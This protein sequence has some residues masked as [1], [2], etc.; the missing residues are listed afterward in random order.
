MRSAFSHCDCHSLKCP[1]F[2]I[3]FTDNIVTENT[4][5]MIFSL[6]LNKTD[7]NEFT[8]FVSNAISSQKKMSVIQ[9]SLL[10]V[11]LAQFV[12]SYN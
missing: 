1:C 12:Q 4:K 11:F 7:E 5:I 2:L 9:K 6:I 8:F 3:F 10:Q